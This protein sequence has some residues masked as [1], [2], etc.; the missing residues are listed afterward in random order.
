MKQLLAVFIL[1]AFIMIVDCG[2]KK[3]VTKTKPKKTKTELE[4]TKDNTI[5]CIDFCFNPP[6]AFDFQ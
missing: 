5:S 4:K 3:T 1:F 6:A 2:D